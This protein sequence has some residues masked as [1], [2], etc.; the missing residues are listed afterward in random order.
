MLPPIPGSIS[1][2]T[3]FFLIASGLL[4]LEEIGHYVRIILIQ[5]H[6]VLFAELCKPKKVKNPTY[7]PVSCI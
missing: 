5:L 6:L 2:R 3:S 1:N 7:L 4:T